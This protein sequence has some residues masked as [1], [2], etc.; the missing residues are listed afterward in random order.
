MHEHAGAFFL[1]LIGEPH[2][3]SRE[4]LRQLRCVVQARQEA[5]RQFR[6]GARRQLPFQLALSVVGQ[7][8]VRVVD[9]L[10]EASGRYPSAMSLR[11]AARS[12]DHHACD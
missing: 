4:R 10:G 12:S 7:E 8:T 3:L 6:P 11:L 5:H 1:P 9:D 2:D